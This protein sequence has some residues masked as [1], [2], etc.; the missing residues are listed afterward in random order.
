MPLSIPEPQP[1]QQS[2]LWIAML[3]VAAPLLV[4][5]GIIGTKPL[6]ASAARSA[7][8]APL[9]AAIPTIE[10]TPVVAPPPPPAVALAAAPPPAV[11]LQPL[12][13]VAAAR[14]AAGG[15][16][17]PGRTAPPHKPPRAPKPPLPVA[18]NR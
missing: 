10:A 12:G 7:A 18:I 9:A 14:P 11:N 4:L 17:K 1:A 2:K 8:E 16:H 15:E 5:A 13:A 6:R 3:L